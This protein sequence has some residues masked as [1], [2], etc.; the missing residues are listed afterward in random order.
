M[1]WPILWTIRRSA[2]VVLGRF[3]VLVFEFLQRRVG[4]ADAEHVDAAERRV[5]IAEAVEGVAGEGRTGHV[6][7]RQSQLRDDAG[8]IQREK[9]RALLA[10][11]GE[12][13]LA[14]RGGRRERRPAALFAERSGGS[15]SAKWPS[16]IPAGRRRI[17]ATSIIGTP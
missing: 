3:A 6:G 2:S 4:Q 11:S 8:M 17:A 12:I 16:R 15:R 13:N 1:S 10:G 7:L 14:V 9:P 5:K